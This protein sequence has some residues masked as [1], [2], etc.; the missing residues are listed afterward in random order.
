MIVTEEYM[1]RKDGVVLMRT[2]SDNKKMIEQVGTGNRYS[3]A[4]D[5]SPVRYTY[6][7]TEEDIPMGA[8]E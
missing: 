5:I 7:E 8:R 2:Y 6:I 4:I 3:G 1:T